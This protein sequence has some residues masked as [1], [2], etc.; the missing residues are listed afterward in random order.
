MNKKILLV[1]SFLLIAGCFL[2]SFFV[3]SAKTS[4]PAMASLIIPPDTISTPPSNIL[5]PNPKL[6]TISVPDSQAS[7]D[8]SNITMLFLG[9][10]M[11]GRYVRTLMEKSGDLNYPFLKAKTT[12]GPGAN[13][14]NGYFDRVIANLEGPIVP[15]PNRAQTGTN[16]GFA[17]DTGKILKQNG[18]DLVSLGNNHTLDQGQKGY[19]STKKYLNEAQLPFFGHPILPT[20]ADTHIETIKGKTFAFV[21][22]HDATRRLDDNGA[23]ALLQKIDPQVDYMIVFI[24]WGPEYQKN[25]SARQVQLAHLFIDHGADLVI[26][27]HPHIPQTREQYK[28]V[29]IVYSLG[30]F[31]FDQYWSDMTQHGLTIEAIFSTDRANKAVQLVEHPVD[32][33]KSQPRWK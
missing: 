14:L 32:L 13:F 3:M 2:V 27:H 19:D 22:F 30:N 15:V 20:E 29:E 16:F 4:R 28:G 6:V 12:T 24:H 5:D 31:I 1:S 8:P 33:P 17:P 23:R 10:I 18:I 26:G 7:T 9:D 11:L 21:G 25:P